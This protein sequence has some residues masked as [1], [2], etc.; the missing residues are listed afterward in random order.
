MMAAAWNVPPGTK[1]SARPGTFFPEAEAIIA[2]AERLT[3]LASSSARP[4]WRLPGSF[5]SV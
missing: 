2:A 4:T 1:S 5:V 3:C